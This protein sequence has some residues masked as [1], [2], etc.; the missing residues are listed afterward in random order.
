MRAQI[1]RWRLD[2]FRR[3][4][5]GIGFADLTPGT[6]FEIAGGDVVSA[7]PELA[8]LILISRCRIGSEEDARRGEQYGGSGFLVGIPFKDKPSWLHCYAVTNAHVIEGGY[9]VVRVS[10]SQP[11]A[12]NKTVPIPFT[13]DNWIH[14]PG[15]DDIAIAPIELAQDR[16]Q[17]IFIVPGSTTGGFFISKQIQ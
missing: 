2:E 5:R 16:H 14:H 7:A 13:Q 6:I 9:P 10:S 8:R 4:V 11:H 1:Q 17:F 12:E 3:A 15:G